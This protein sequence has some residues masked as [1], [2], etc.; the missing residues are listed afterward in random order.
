[1]MKILRHLCLVFVVLSSATLF[2]QHVEISGNNK[3]IAVSA[4]ASVSADPEIAILHLAFTNYAKAKEDAFQTNVSVSNQILSK[5]AEAGVKKE[6]IESDDLSLDR[7][8]PIN[9]WTAVERAERQFK[10]RQAW[11]IRVPVARA[12]SIVQAA[13]KAGAN[14][15][16]EPDWQVA[17]QTALQARASADALERAKRIAEEMAKGLGTRLGNLV[18]ASNRA[19]AL[20]DFLDRFAWG[21]GG[22]GGNETVEVQAARIEPPLPKLKLFPQ[23]VKENATVFAVFSIE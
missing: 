18:Y 1:M 4:D 5:I 2:S 13:V 22:G 23:K 19:P 8:E 10:A 3:T 16:S 11:K 6:Q 20:T 14:E 9:G 17:N 12:E 15:S 21:G 7:A